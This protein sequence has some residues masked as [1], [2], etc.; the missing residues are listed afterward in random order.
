MDS[1][2]RG[3]NCRGLPNRVKNNSVVNDI[4]IKKQAGTAAFF[5]KS[6][7]FHFWT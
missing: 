5:G 4:V 7:S 6:V 2:F 1:A 3:K